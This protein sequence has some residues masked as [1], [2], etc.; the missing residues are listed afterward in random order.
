MGIKLIT[1]RCDWAWDC[2]PEPHISRLNVFLTQRQRYKENTL[3]LRNKPILNE[4]LFGQVCGP[5]ALLVYLIWW[6]AASTKR[7]YVRP[8]QPTLWQIFCALFVRQSCNCPLRVCDL[9]LINYSFCG[10]PLNSMPVA[11]DESRFETLN[12]SRSGHTIEYV[13]E[14]WFDRKSRLA[15]GCHKNDFPKEIVYCL[16]F[17]LSSELGKHF[18]NIHHTNFSTLF[19]PLR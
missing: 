12:W 3:V 1:I 2:L 5:V 14:N 18:W 8:I 16:T 7:R 6:F 17:S 13:L 10:K 11:R 19:L 4:W 15:R 9:T